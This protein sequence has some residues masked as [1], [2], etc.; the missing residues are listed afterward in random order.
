M[1][2]YSDITELIKSQKNPKTIESMASFEINVTN[3]YGITI[4][5]LRSIAGQ[6]GK[7]NGENSHLLVHQS[8]SSRIHESRIL[9]SM[10]DDSDRSQSIKWMNGLGN[11]IHGIFVTNAAVPC[12]VKP[13]MHLRRQRSGV[14]ERRV[15]KESRVCIDGYSIYT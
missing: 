6:I 2:N 5:F 1:V 9:S 14:G 4:P 11:L 13:H 8:W 12:L 10:I 7:G 15:C 3:A